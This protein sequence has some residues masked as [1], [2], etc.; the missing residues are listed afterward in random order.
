[1]QFKQTT[2]LTSTPQNQW[3]KC[4][5]FTSTIPFYYISQHATSKQRQDLK[6]DYIVLWRSPFKTLSQ[7]SSSKSIGKLQGK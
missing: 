3:L 4:N 6:N 1:M 7:L 5:I 2:I